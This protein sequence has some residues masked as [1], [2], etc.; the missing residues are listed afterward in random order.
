MA[1]GAAW[2]SIAALLKV[3]RGISE[4]ISTIM[5]NFIG[6]AIF[7]YLLASDRLGVKAPGGEI[8]ST[9][10]LPSDSWMPRFPPFAGTT[11]QVFGF[12]LVSAAAGLGRASASTS[13]PRA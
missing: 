8:V 4:V 10:L 1:V 13:V 12:I 6:G 7:A 9:P 2:A 11:N 5:L 3:Y